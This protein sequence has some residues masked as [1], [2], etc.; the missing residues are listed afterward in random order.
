MKALFLGSA[1]LIALATTH[2]VHA[3]G[4]IAK[5]KRAY[6]DKVQATFKANAPVMMQFGQL[7]QTEVPL[8]KQLKEHKI[9][10]KQ[11]AARAPKPAVWQ[12]VIPKMRV[13]VRQFSSIKPVPPSMASVNNSLLSFSTSMDKALVQLDRWTRTQKQADFNTALTG[14]FTAYKPLMIAA[15]TAREKMGGTLKPR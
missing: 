10:A 3:Q 2:P 6:S 5:D 9:T 11:Y 1:L 13:A 12:A 15:K 7:L 14:L 8:Q 4:N